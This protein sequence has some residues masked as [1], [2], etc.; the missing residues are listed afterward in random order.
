MHH[1]DEQ[2]VMAPLNLERLFKAWAEIK[3]K[4]ANK[5]G[6]RR[7]ASVSRICGSVSDKRS[8]GSGGG[9]S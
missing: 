6:N 4:E 2:K 7:V 1:M 5:N 9:A 8:P 3:W